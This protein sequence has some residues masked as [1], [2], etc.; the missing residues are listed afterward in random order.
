MLNSFWHSYWT[1]AISSFES[2]MIHTICE[3]EGTHAEVHQTIS[4]IVLLFQIKK[5]GILLVL[6][7][8]PFSR[9]F[10]SVH[11]GT[12]KR[13]SPFTWPQL[14]IIWWEYL[15]STAH[16][17]K[18]CKSEPILQMIDK[19]QKKQKKNTKKWEW[20]SYSYKPCLAPVYPQYQRGTD[21]IR[22]SSLKHV[23]F[24]PQRLI[25]MCQLC[26][27]QS[28][29]VEGLQVVIYKAELQLLDL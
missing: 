21:G 22:M 3:L 4:H 26:W 16:V 12:S 10:F 14:I 25:R 27:W 18:A 19:K 15:I 23:R 6:W 1:F 13:W 11:Y 20:S 29:L 24:F 7:H 5:K 28:Y 2:C 8:W 9:K 17:Y